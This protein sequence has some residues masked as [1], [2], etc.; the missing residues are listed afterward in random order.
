MNNAQPWKRI[1]AA[2][3][4]VAGGLIAGG[5]LA[6][7]LSASAA[8]GTTTTTGT[9]SSTGQPGGDPSQ[10][11]SPDEQLLTGNTKTQVEKA[12]T[13]AYPGATIERTESDSGGVYESHVV[14]AD[15]GHLI[16]LVGA[17][18]SVTGTDTGGPGGGGAPR[19]SGGA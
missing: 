17:D 16:V 2:A 15:G 5:V 11:Q 10:P 18:F 14:T 12:V 7:T 1:G 8:E 3:G 6:G 13:A 4:L 19:G 9:G